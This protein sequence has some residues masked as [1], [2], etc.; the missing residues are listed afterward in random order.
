M[1]KKYLYSLLIII[2]LLAT[3]CNS[4]NKKDIKKD[5]NDE[6]ISTMKVIINEEEYIVELEDNYTV[7]SFISLLPKEI[8]M[9]ELNGNEKYAYLDETL[10][11]DSYNPKRI[12]SGDV[13][14]FGNN[15][16]VIFYES[17]DTSYS[18]TKIG[19]IDNLP[20]LNEENVLVRFE[21]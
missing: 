8:N 3:G 12:N 14:L 6:E 1:K 18:Y 10:P 5:V 11:T 21:K 19:H 7:K 4:D 16:I 9:L 2:L 20:K 13:M 15:C 17:F